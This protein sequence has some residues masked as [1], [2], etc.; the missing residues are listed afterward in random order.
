MSSDR[1]KARAGLEARRWLQWLAPVALCAVA[2][3]QLYLATGHGLSPWKGGGF[4]MFSGYGDRALRVIVTTQR[5]DYELTPEQIGTASIQSVIYFPTHA[6]LRELAHA[7]AA[8]DFTWRVEGRA[9][10][11]ILAGQQATEPKAYYRAKISAVRFELRELSLDRPNNQLAT[12]VVQ[13]A[14]IAIAP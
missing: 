10:S 5:G 13:D 11:L 9:S 4:G 14:S 12:R 6:R 2:G 7:L 1:S 8:R 3:L